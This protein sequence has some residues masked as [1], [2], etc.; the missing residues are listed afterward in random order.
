MNLFNMAAIDTPIPVAETLAAW[1]QL[2]LGLAALFVM[3]LGLV[4]VI[5]ISLTI[6][7]M[8]KNS[9]DAEVAL[10]KKES[11]TAETIH[12][13]VTTLAGMIDDYRQLRD[14]AEKKLEQEKHQNTVNLDAIAAVN[15][16][17]AE[18][19]GGL[20]QQMMYG[21]EQDFK[22]DLLLKGLSE[23]MEDVAKATPLLSKLEQIETAIV[24][25]KT[26]IEGIKPVP[27][28]ISQQLDEIKQKLDEVMQMLADLQKEPPPEPKL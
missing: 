26:A 2:G 21:N 17:M 4:T 20:K 1:G 6:K 13:T 16:K 25:Q 24:D 15:E 9:P 14:D 5:V 7:Q 28:T 27:E 8:R 19:L 18:M 3:C 12:S 22:R 23:S 11:V 10:A